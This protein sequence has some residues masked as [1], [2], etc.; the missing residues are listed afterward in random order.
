MHREI[1][2]LESF[3]FKVKQVFK[4]D[5]APPIVLRSNEGFQEEQ[6]AIYQMRANHENKHYG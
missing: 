4:D 2:D 5:K 3:L 6:L 1:E